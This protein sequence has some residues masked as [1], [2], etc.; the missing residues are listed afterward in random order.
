MLKSCYILLQIKIS[1]D[2]FKLNMVF[3]CDNE[4][5]HFYL[6]ISNKFQY[7]YESY[8]NFFYI[9]FLELNTKP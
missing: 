3:K 5:K 1:D 2:F 4:V 9:K 8:G 6:E 7:A